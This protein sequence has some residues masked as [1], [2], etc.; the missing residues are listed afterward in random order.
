[1][2]SCLIRKIVVFSYLIVLSLQISVKLSS[3]YDKCFFE[4]LYSTDHLLSYTIHGSESIEEKDKI[5]VISTI[6]FK[7][8]KIN[9]NDNNKELVQVE[10][11]TQVKG[12]FI[13]K[14]KK[15]GEYKICLSFNGGYWEKKLQ[16]SLEYQ[17][18]SKHSGF[19]G[20]DKA[21]KNE[22]I[23]EMHLT[24]RSTIRNVD[25]ALYGFKNELELEEKDASKIERSASFF[26]KLT[27]VQV[28]I[29]VLLFAYQLYQAKQI[30]KSINK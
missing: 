28:L 16:L 26:Y 17:L 5:N 29:I 6:V 25:N 14:E 8:Y 3:K 1:M 23:E 20:L 30:I 22:H 27:I 18:T 15:N 21:V 7:V 12:K 24:L 11:A 10:N 19:H 9:L 4:D 13:I 2:E